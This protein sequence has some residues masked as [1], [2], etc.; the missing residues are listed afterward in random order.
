MEF[1][2]TAFIFHKDKLLF[3][4]HKKHRLWMHVGGHMEKGESFEESLLR[5]IREEVGLDVAFIDP[6]DLEMEVTDVVKPLC[7]PF[8]IH[9][10]INPEGKRYVALDYV[11]EA[12]SDE[13][14]L[15]ETEL[16]DYCWVRREDIDGLE[17]YDYLKRLA[18]N[19]FDFYSNPRKYSRETLSPL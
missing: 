5:E 15:Q 8:F 7:N 1:I 3:V 18:K 17:T 2:T 14:R 13:V 4:L 10:G 16:L 11:C 6:F 19:A 9:D 12:T